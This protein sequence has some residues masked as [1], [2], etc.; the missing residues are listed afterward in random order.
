MLGVLHLWKLCD[1]I[2]CNGLT[3]NF[4]FPLFLPFLLPFLLLPLSLFSS[5]LSLPIL[6][7]PLSLSSSLPLSLPPLSL[8]PFII[9]LLLL[10]FLLSAFSHYLWEPIFVILV[11]VKK[12]GLSLRL[13][14]RSSW[15]LDPRNP[16]PAF[17]RFLFPRNLHLCAFL[18]RSTPHPENP[19]RIRA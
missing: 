6:L 19:F 8:L 5:S 7:L 13:I 12:Q 9:P 15:S 14:Q 3:C 4:P 18:K 16:L 17:R 10:S 2:T 1:G 11:F